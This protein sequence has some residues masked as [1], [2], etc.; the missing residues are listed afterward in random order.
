MGFD[1]GRV[2]TAVATGGISEIVRPGLEAPGD[3]ADAQVA[4]GRDALAFGAEQTGPFRDIG[5]AAG[6]Q[7]PGAQFAGF[8]RDPSRVLDNPLFKALMEQQNQDL[9]NQ[10]GALGRGGSGETND[11]LTQNLLKTGANFQQQDFQ[12]QL[13]ENQQQFGQ[14]FDQTR[15]G[16]NVAT[17]Q[18][19]SGQNIIQGIGNA[20]AAGITGKA[21]AIN[22]IIG[23]GIGLG[24]AA[25]TGGASL[26]FTG[27]G[28]G[29]STGGQSFSDV[30]L[31]EN[32]KYSHSENG[33]NVYTWDWAKDALDLVDGQDTKGPLAQE[34]KETHPDAVTIDLSGFYKVNNEV[35]AWH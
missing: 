32:I 8:D 15:L 26:P 21:N 33:I 10:Q 14:L 19:T 7:L 4:A 11:L 30:R 27:G 16:A 28:G 29:V 18:A 1:F 23:Q 24:A 6:E 5:I 31:K 35:L 13:V 12:N 20:E 3:A 25:L 17:N 2:L 34:L 22:N 9:I